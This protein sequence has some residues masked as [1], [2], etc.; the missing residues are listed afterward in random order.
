MFASV[1]TVAVY[2]S[3]MERAKRFYTE[4]LGFKIKYDIGPTLCF[5]V[6]ESG[7]INVYLEAGNKP[8]AVNG[9]STRLSFFLWT[10]NTVRET[11]DELKVKGVTILDKEPEEVGNGVYVFRFLDPDRNILEA[12]GH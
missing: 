11:F 8:A 3:D 12:T 7:N 2:V 6:S 1:N 5:L 10:V 4:I 9:E